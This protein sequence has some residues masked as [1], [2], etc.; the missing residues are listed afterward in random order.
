VDP[1]AIINFGKPA[2]SGL[3]SQDANG[4]SAAPI[5]DILSSQAL[6]G[7]EVQTPDAV[8]MSNISPNRIDDEIRK[9]GQDL[10][11]M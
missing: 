1:D 10:Q 4:G 9:Q 3:L 2:Q 11:E 7:T 8:D 6:E 5:H